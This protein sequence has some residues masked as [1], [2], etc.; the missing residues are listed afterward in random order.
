MRRHALFLAVTLPLSAQGLPWDI[1]HRGALIYQRQTTAYDFDVGQS[2]MRPEWFV[3]RGDEGGHEWR[4]LACARGRVPAG[5]E[6]ATFAD[7]D[8]LLGK[9]GFGTEVGKDA[10]QRSPWTTHELVLRTKIDLGRRKPKMAM[11][12]VDHDD[13]LRIWWN[14]KLVVG[15]DGYG[16]NRSYVVA[17]DALDAWQR[18]DNL[19]VVQCSQIGGTQYLDLGLCFFHTLPA[20][21]KDGPGLQQA[22]TA[23]R[24][25]ADKIRGDL[26]GAFRPPPLL[27][28][29]EL[30]KDQDQVRLPPGDLRELAWWAATDLSKGATGGTMNR[31]ATRL[32]R[33][34][35]LQLKGKVAAIDAEG[36]QTLELTVR[37]QDLDL[38]DDSKRFVDRWIRPYVWVRLRWQARHPPARR[39]ARRQGPRR[40]I[41][42]EAARHVPA[43]QGRQGAGRHHRARRDLAP[44][45]GPR[46]PGRG[47]PRRRCQGARTRL[48]AAARPTG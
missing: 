15:D 16:R 33:L 26:F 41:H 21:V 35:D 42:D 23:E 6:Q 19:L 40:R 2:R 36:W 4:Y 43:R 24:G 25:A 22:I 10:T 37:S 44:A 9:T 32:L 12:L 48:R 38:L 18:G 29:G 13:G 7:Q 14:G 31:T 5:V 1:P 8:W 34:G 47:V 17:G 30:G 39:T 27:L 20:G 45:C 11:F 3:R 46:R 28:Q